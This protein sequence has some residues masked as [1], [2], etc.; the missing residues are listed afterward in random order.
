MSKKRTAKQLK[1]YQYSIKGDRPLS[2]SPISV[3]LPEDVDAFVRS[4]PN[5]SQWLVE[6]ILDKAAKEA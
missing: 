6:A 2:K 3:R 5:R 4:L 1:D